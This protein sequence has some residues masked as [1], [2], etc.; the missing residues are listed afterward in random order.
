[1]ISRCPAVRTSVAE[2]S[3]VQWSSQDYQSLDC[4][5]DANPAQRLPANCEVRG[6]GGRGGEGGTP[7]LSV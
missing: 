3:G 7:T 4:A 2:S 1:M 6:E 5:R